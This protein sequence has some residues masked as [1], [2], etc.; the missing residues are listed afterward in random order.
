MKLLVNIVIL[1]LF[2]NSWSSPLMAQPNCHNVNEKNYFQFSIAQY[3]TQRQSGQTINVYVRYAYTPHLSQD[4]YPDYRV[5]RTAILKYMEPSKELPAEVYWEIIATQMGK[6]LMKNFPI[7]GVS[8]QLDVKGNENPDP[9]KSEP[10]DHGPI[11]TIGDIAPL[12]I[13]H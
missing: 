9:N 10:G 13:H 2:I 1:N 7:S 4:K 11:F 8:I 5:L 3:H 12:D 6:E